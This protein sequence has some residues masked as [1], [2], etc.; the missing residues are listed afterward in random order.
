MPTIVTQNQL[1]ELR[2]GDRVRYH[3]VDWDI[4]DYSRYQDP[5]GYETDEWLLK[6]R[7]GSEYY[8]LREFDPNQA[9]NTVNWYLAQELPNVSLFL[10]DS[11][12]N[13]A[14]KLW[15]DM[16][17]TEPYPE[18]K[19]F[20]KSYYFESQTQGTYQAEGETR[21]RITWDYWDQDHQINLAIEAFA[22]GQLDIYS[23]KVV[24]PE[25]FSQI[26]KEIEIKRGINAI[27]PGKIIQLILASLTLIIGIWLMIF[28]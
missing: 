7:G 1:Q 16:P 10:P 11:P 24:Q 8:L 17:K 12:E 9:L 21:S 25:E 26:Q 6:S 13:I 28:G 14:P 23:T 3:G 5:Q 18:L 2:P 4:E 27:N 20:Y 19:L 22:D 15:Q